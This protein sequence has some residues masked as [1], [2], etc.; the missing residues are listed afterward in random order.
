M[1]KPDRKVAPY[2]K[3]IVIN[4]FIEPENIQLKN[5]LPV[6]LISGGTQPVVKIDFIFQ[7]GYWYQKQPLI[8]STVSSMLIEGSKKYTSSE[9]AEKLDYYGAFLSQ[10]SNNDTAIV[11]LY[12][13]TKFLPETLDITEEIIKNSIFPERE[14]KINLKRRK[15]MFLV[16]QERTRT[17][18]NRKL[19][20]VLFGNNHPYSKILKADDYDNINSESL[21]SYYDYYFSSLNCKVIAAGNLD[22]KFLTLIEERFGSDDWIKKNKHDDLVYAI[23]TKS[24]KKHYVKKEG[25]VQSAISIGKVLFNRLHTDFMELKFLT[26]LFGGYFGSRLMKNIREEKGY[27]YGIS[28]SVVSFLHSGIFVINTEVKSEVTNNALKEIYYE[29]DR[30]KE[31]LVPENELEKVKNYILGDLLIMFDGP[32]ALSDSFRLVNDYNLNFN[33]YKQYIEKIKNITSERIKE[34]ATMYL[35]K[36]DMIEIV[37]GP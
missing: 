28:S 3:P 14:L 4:E 20:E 21:L 10:N 32:F 37:A 6:Y 11:T 31:E 9:I 2:I 26:V 13:L 33:Y 5:K 29:L 18:A 19:N 27:T 8:A 7:A 16:E 24:K 30:L 15:Q 22:T 1:L 36:S 34:L 17:L 12:T 23:Q 25:A 35:D